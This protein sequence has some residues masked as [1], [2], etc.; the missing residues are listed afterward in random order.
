[1]RSKILLFLFSAVLTVGAV[2]GVT[3]FAKAAVTEVGPPIYK[4]FKDTT[5]GPRSVFPLASFMMSGDNSS[6]LTKVG[7]NIRAS[8]TMDNLTQISGVALY[9]ESGTNS[10]FNPNEDTY[11]P[12]SYRPSAAL[13][14]TTMTI[15]DMGAG[16][17][18]P[19][20]NS[21]F[22]LV[23]STSAMTSIIN[24]NAFDVVIASG[25]A[26]TSAPSIIGS[27]SPE[28]P[29]KFIL[30]KTVPVKISEIKAGSTG[31]GKD[32]F[33][34]LYNP[35]D[36]YINL[37][38]I[39]TDGDLALYGYGT[40]T[41]F[42]LTFSPNKNYI[43]PFSY[44]LLTSATNYSGSVSADATFSNLTSDLLIA[45]GGLLIA[46]ST[47]AANATSTKVDMLGYGTQMSVNCENSD[48]AGSCLRRRFS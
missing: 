47:V 17:V 21:E 18:V 26:S 34:E 16:Y 1:M 48:T 27:N 25:Y 9:K 22:Y 36:F 39:K 43:A 46:T 40:S 3:N 41:H 14:T 15:I 6:T 32:E 19:I 7:F 31:N 12:G 4:M 13:S 42:A 29:K 8:S 2:F 38:Q 44:F 20:S 37:N 11:L 28:N 45:N 35:N 30:Q 23:A 5:V 24:G 10:G 33:V